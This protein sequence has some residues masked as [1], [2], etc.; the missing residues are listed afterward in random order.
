MVEAGVPLPK[1]AEIVGWS[2][3]TMC[4]MIKRY[5]HMSNAALRQVVASLEISSISESSAGVIGEKRAEQNAGEN[6]A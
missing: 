1:I 6:A 2:A 4:L 5:G 3:G